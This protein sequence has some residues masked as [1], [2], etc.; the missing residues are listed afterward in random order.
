MKISEIP[1]KERAGMDCFSVFCG[2]FLKGP[3]GFLDA[4]E[5]L[6]FKICPLIPRIN[7]NSFNFR[8]FSGKI[9]ILHLVIS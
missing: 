7:A 6:W 9:L 5:P 2:N 1:V 3:G 4:L 8:V